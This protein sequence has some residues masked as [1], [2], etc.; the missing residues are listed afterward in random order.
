MWSRI[1]GWFAALP[2]GRKWLTVLAA[3]VA[4]GAADILT[5]CEVAL[6][7]L[8]VFPITL[9]TWYL[10]KR[11]GALVGAL[12][13][14][15]V[16]GPDMLESRLA[17]DHP[18]Y[19]PV[20][21]SASCGAFLLIVFAMNTLRSRL[22]HERQLARRDS[23]TGLLNRRAFSELLDEYLRQADHARRPL[24]LAYLD[25]DDFK[26][27]NDDIG[28]HGGDHVLEL[29]GDL[30]ARNCRTGDVVA[31]VG[32]DEFALL[33]PDAERLDAERLI[34]RLQDSLNRT[35]ADDRQVVTC[36][37][38]VVTFQTPPRSSKVAM[39]MADTVMYRVKSQGKNAV[40]FVVAEA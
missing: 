28:H 10:G 29:V 3:W 5:G 4:A 16:V 33:L 6:A 23:L 36:S 34:A 9:A 19:L 40:D 1:D 25:V 18:C 11:S 13:S 15:L 21:W 31:R 27:I 8:Y 38:G 37:I 35:F 20:K 12:S 7:V 2:P 30:L 22:D 26:T 24:S 17:I 32:G 39:M 14:I